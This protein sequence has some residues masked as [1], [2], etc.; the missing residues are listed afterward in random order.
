MSN[1]AC[2]G[3]C[4][5][6]FF[7]CCCDRS[8]S[9]LARHAPLSLCIRRVSGPLE[10][11]TL[12]VCRERGALAGL[13]EVIPLSLA[14][15]S[16]AARD[17][18]QWCARWMLNSR[19]L[20]ALIRATPDQIFVVVLLN[21]FE[22]CCIESS[23]RPG[24]FK[25]FPALHFLLAPVVKAGAACDDVLDASKRCSNGAP[26]DAPSPSK[27]AKAAF[28]VAPMQGQIEIERVLGVRKHLR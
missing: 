28:D 12:H 23:V 26:E 6:C 25:N 13:V 11:T 14:R 5:F 17:K 4:C 1:Y 10:P 8:K 15:S 21:A 16:G 9:I 2:S 20:H 19:R 7:Y 24:C 18:K 27:Q 3:C 22:H